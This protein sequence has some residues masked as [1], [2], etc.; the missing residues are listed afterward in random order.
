VTS[1]AQLDALEQRLALQRGVARQRFAALRSQLRRQ[2]TAPATL[3]CA[4]GVGVLVEQGSRGSGRSMAGLWRAASVTTTLLNSVR[5][6]LV[7]LDA[8]QP[9]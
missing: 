7:T 2:S 1:R 3:L 9:G 8:T 5:D 4:V 6:L